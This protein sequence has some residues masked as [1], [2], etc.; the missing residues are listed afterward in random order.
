MIITCPSAWATESPRGTFSRWC[1]ASENLSV[2]ALIID[3]DIK[4][5][6][7]N[8]SGKSFFLLSWAKK[9]PKNLEAKRTCFVLNEDLFVWHC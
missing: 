1:D 7:A 3:S 8:S 5:N 9:K 6:E 2:I 4:G